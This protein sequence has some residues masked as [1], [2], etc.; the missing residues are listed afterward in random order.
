MSRF[1]SPKMLPLPSVHVRDV[2]R[3]L[4]ASVRGWVSGQS[5]LA[6]AAAQRGQ[7]SHAPGRVD[8]AAQV[9]E[10][11]RSLTKKGLLCLV[12]KQFPAL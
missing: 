2:Q 9:R 5:Q 3:L 8:E 10:K 7:R 6:G 12:N 11:T 1:V 4:P